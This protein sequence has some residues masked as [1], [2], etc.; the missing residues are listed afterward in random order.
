MEIYSKALKHCL[1]RLWVVGA[2]KSEICR[3]GLQA[4]NSGSTSTFTGSL[5]NSLFVKPQSLFLR[6]T[7]WMRTT[8]MIKAHLCFSKYTDLDISHF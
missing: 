8:H 5:E 1:M 4:G 3:V 7:C 6:S 2:G